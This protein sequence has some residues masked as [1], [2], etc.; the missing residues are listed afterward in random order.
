MKRLLSLLMVILMVLPILAGCGGN[1]VNLDSEMDMPSLTDKPSESVSTSQ[2]TDTE[3]EET[4]EESS[5]ATE[6][7]DTE[8]IDTESDT[9]SDTET[10]TESD[11]E[12]TEETEKTDT[13]SSDNVSN[14]GFEGVTSFSVYT[15][16][17]TKI[18]LTA[19]ITSSAVKT[20]AQSEKLTVVAKKGTEWYKVKYGRFQGYVPQDF[21]TTDI[22]D[23][24]FNNLLTFDQKA[25]TVK[26]GKNATIHQYPF[27]SNL[28]EQK[29]LTLKNSDTSNEE[30]IKTGENNSGTLYKVSY[31]G[32]TYYIK[33]QS[34]SSLLFNDI[35]FDNSGI[36]GSTEI[37]DSSIY[38][39]MNIEELL[40]PNKF[41]G[42]DIY[43][44][45]DYNNYNF[46]I[47]LDNTN[48]NKE[49]ILESD[50]ELIKDSLINRQEY[51]EEYLGISFAFTET[52]GGYS[53][54]E[55]FALEIEIANQVGYSYDLALAYNL[56][57][58][59]VA[60]KGLSKNLADSMT[61]NPFYTQKEYWSKDFIRTARIG[62]KIFWITDMSSWN[63]ISNM[64]CIY[65]N[66][67]Y[68]KDVNTRMD[69]YDLYDLVD[70]KQW[71]MENMLILAQGAYD[72][73]NMDKRVDDGD[74]FGLQAAEYASSLDLWINAAGFK[75]VE[76]NAHGQRSWMFDNKDTKE[77][78]DWWQSKLK[79]DA[80]DN[81]NNSNVNMFKQSRAMFSCCNVAMVESQGI[82]FNY[83]VL[84]MPMYTASIKDGYS[85]PL[86]NSY[87][88]YMIPSGLNSTEFERSANV[89][90]LLAAEGN[91]RLAPTYFEIFL[92]RM[93]AADDPDMQRMFNIIRS[94][95]VFDFGMICGSALTVNN[96]TGSG[97]SE[98][99]IM[100]RRVWSGYS[101]Y[102]DIDY[103]WSEI[104][105]TATSKLNNFVTSL[106]K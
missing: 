12:E 84:P 11:S 22:D 26:T 18:N 95:V 90:D 42:S 2:T 55:F 67:T 80:V 57:G 79:N 91:R 94:S 50:G 40:N 30:L 83:T 105:S 48:S 66:E 96:L 87:T 97:E 101:V 99:F 52:L 1:N 69:K 9:E 82:E 32:E 71:T 81:G 47:L 28:I 24:I 21:V 38:D 78:I 106:E 100:L 46:K 35:E 77:F 89:L 72:D 45:I 58:A 59:V 34:S 70:N 92:K 19:S 93:T 27:T 73:T 7:I 74:S 13:D 64:L 75:L 65:V 4:S 31:M 8:A 15:Y 62:S 103:V 5:E 102:T 49:F 61:L 29:E 41:Q 60:A 6:P 104:N 43:S 14:D 17:P 10:E 3:S 56:I 44:S 39:D 54:M 63:T 20:T 37:I 36:G 76:A 86:T 33:A 68:F 25:I 51:V 53:N 16:I 23:T 88:S 85:T 98:V